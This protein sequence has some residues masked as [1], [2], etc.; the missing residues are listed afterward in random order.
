MVKH[1]IQQKV[2]TSKGSLRVVGQKNSK[3]REVLSTGGVESPKLW[4]KNGRARFFRI[5]GVTT[6]RGPGL[7]QLY[8]PYIVVIVVRNQ[9]GYGPFL[10]DITIDPNIPNGSNELRSLS[11]YIRKKIFTDVRHVRISFWGWCSSSEPVD[12]SKL[13]TPKLW[14]VNTKLD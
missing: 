12:G 11:F 8:Q 3:G 7:V 9:F 2:A 4:S 6:E 13:G 1:H 10:R 5:S 14:M